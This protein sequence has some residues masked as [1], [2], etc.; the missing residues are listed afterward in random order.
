MFGIII[1]LI[2]Y[3]LPWVIIPAMAVLIW[4]LRRR[5]L[6]ALLALAALVL[7]AV[8]HSREFLYSIGLGL[9]RDDEPGP[10]IS[11]FSALVSAAEWYAWQNLALAAVSAAVLSWPLPDGRGKRVLAVMVVVWL[12][13]SAALVWLFSEVRFI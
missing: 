4:L 7:V 5:L 2:F 8:T 11:A 3:I 10:L 6:R 1:A 9:P 13:V 12:G